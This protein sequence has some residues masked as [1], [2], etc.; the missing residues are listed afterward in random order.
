MNYHNL[1]LEM[2]DLLFIANQLQYLIKESED[3][4]SWDH[5][6][7]RGGSDLTTT[8]LRIEK[9]ILLNGR[10]KPRDI[11]QKLEGFEKKISNLSTYFI[12]MDPEFRSSIIK[13]TQE[14]EDLDFT[15]DL[16][17]T[18]ASYERGSVKLRNYI[19]LTKGASKTGPKNQ[20]TFHIAHAAAR[21]YYINIGTLPAP[22]DK[23]GH[24]AL[25]KTVHSICERFQRNPNG[26]Y[27][28]RIRGVRYQCKKALLNLNK[29]NANLAFPYI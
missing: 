25:V 2:D 11:L 1:N 6:Q 26:E 13:S 14:L 3:L 12:N 15:Q 4:A 23:W 27:R 19:E 9:C 21:Y 5:V 16:L 7:K 29:S 10:Y 20:R 18:L 28:D 24:Q 17:K 22:K 8:V